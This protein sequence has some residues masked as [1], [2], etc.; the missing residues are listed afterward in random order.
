MILRVTVSIKTSYKYVT[1]NFNERQVQLYQNSKVIEA[2][3]LSSHISISLLLD[4][5]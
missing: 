4:I 3:I 5:T 1:E 2:N